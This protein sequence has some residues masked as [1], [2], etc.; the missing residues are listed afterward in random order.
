M[1]VARVSAA[2]KVPTCQGLGQIC[3]GQWHLTHQEQIYFSQSHIYINYKHNYTPKKNKELLVVLT[4]TIIDLCHVH[5]G[6]PQHTHGSYIPWQLLGFLSHISP[7]GVQDSSPSHQAWQLVCHLLSHLA[8]HHVPRLLIPI[9]KMKL[10]LFHSFA[11]GLFF[12]YGLY[13]L[14]SFSSNPLLI[15]LRKRKGRMSAVQL[16]IFVQACWVKYVSKAR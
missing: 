2:A 11:H 10:H 15:L 13:L 6:V 3:E 14:H 4:L 9:H 8:T 7:C 5:M 1:E 16:M 12:I